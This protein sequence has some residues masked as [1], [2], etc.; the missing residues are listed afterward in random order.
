MNRTKSVRL[1]PEELE[2]LKTYRNE[3]YDDGIPLG[4]VIDQLVEEVSDDG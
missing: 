1:S 2:K 3:V 4:F